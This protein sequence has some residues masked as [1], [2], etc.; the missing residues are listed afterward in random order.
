MFGK[1]APASAYY[2]RWYRGLQLFYNDEGKEFFLIRP[3]FEDKSKELFTFRIG[4]EALI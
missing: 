2:Y 1:P 3:S 4:Y